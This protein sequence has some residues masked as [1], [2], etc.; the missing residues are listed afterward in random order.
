MV[1]KTVSKERM[2]VF[3]DKTYLNPLKRAEL[4]K[5]I[6]SLDQNAK[7]IDGV[8]DPSKPWL[9]NPRN[10]NISDLRRQISKLKK[11]IATRTAPEVDVKTRN[12]Y[13]QR[14]KYLE[15]EIKK[16]MPTY[17]EMM[18]KRYVGSDAKPY[19]VAS[20]HAI[21]KQMDWQT[22]QDGNIREWKQIMR[23]LEP[24]DPNIANVERLR[25]R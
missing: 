25:R 24:S 20:E 6:K 5:Q 12:K 8:I 18:G 23:I 22:K 3:N 19:V 21:R 2:P 4:E 15:S 9:Y 14:A 13:L 11:T 16:E 7:I 17:D 1:K 10:T